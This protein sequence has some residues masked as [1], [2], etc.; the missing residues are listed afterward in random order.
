[1]KIC[2]PSTGKGTMFSSTARVICK[3]KKEEEINV[4]V[5]FN[6]Y[7]IGGSKNYCLRCNFCHLLLALRRRE[8]FNGK[9]EKVGK[10]RMTSRTV[11][12][13]VGTE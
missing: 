11:R 1:M 5:A 6:C 10:M 8:F 7:R 4:Y 9:I 2:Y 3:H 13:I 12:G